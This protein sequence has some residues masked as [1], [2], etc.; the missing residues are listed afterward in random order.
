MSRNPLV[1]VLAASSLVPDHLGASLAVVDI[2]SDADHAAGEHVVGRCDLDGPRA[3]QAPEHLDGGDW[4]CC[5]VHAP[6]D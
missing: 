5:Y 1:T 3:A 6:P 2:G 4:P